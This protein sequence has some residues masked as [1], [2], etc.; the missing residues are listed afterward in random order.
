MPRL[1]SAAADNRYEYYVIQDHSS[2]IDSN[3]GTTL[4]LPSVELYLLQYPLQQ[5]S[6]AAQDTI[7]SAATQTDTCPWLIEHVIG[8]TKRIGIWLSVSA[9]VLY[10]RVRLSTATLDTR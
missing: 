7:F 10:Y 5:N 4:E 6:T 8:E 9:T 1:R 3:N 2:S